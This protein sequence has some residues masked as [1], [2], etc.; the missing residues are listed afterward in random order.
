MNQYLKPYQSVWAKKIKNTI[1]LS[2]ISILTAFT[3]AIYAK[4]TDNPMITM[5]IAGQPVYLEL[6][7]TEQQR[8]RGLMYRSVLPKDHGMLFVWEKSAKQCMWM[9]NTPIDLDVAFIRED[10]FIDSVYTMKSNTVDS[11]CSQGPIRYAIEM[12]SGFF[13]GQ[14]RDPDRRR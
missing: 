3:H 6:A 10:G 1:F 9:K 2:G 12:P 11:H 5:T 8:R 4:V 7:M 13:S 14:G